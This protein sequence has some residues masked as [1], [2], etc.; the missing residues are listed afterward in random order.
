M[1]WV[2]ELVEE[3]AKMLWMYGHVGAGKSTITQSLAEQAH[4][5]QK[6]LAAFFFSR[7][8]RSRSPHKTLVS[9][10]AYQA[11]LAIKDLRTLLLNE[12]LKYSSKISP[13]R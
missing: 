5:L 11:A 10:I 2:D 9:T 12:T 4:R 13:L 8:D 3:K 6:L 1:E 7:N